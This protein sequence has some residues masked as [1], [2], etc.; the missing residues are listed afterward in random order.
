[1][2][3]KGETVHALARLSEL[4]CRRTIDALSRCA[5]AVS[6][7]ATAGETTD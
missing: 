7:C 2:H 6:Y 5:L 4:K 1:M 3:M